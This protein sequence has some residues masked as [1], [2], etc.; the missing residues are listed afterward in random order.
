MVHSP[1]LQAEVLGYNDSE[2]EPVILLDG[3]SS[4]RLEISTAIFLGPVYQLSFSRLYLRLSWLR[5]HH[6]PGPC[7]C[8]LL[9]LSRR[10]LLVLVKLLQYGRRCDVS[11]TLLHFP[12]LNTHG[13]CQ[14]LA[15]TCLSKISVTG[16]GAYF[17]YSGHG[18]P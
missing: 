8:G 1:K 13:F 10:V 2:S 17:G 6:P 5:Q 9:T 4:N 11:P 16:G 14:S 15:E 12:Q 18:E 7:L 3:A